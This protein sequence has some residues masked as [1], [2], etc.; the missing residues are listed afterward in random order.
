[1]PVV[2]AIVATVVDIPEEGSAF[3]EVAGDTGL[4][5]EV[6][7]LEDAAFPA[8]RWEGSA[9]FAAAVGE[10]GAWDVAAAIGRR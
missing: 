2:A 10:G 3:E 9:T 1:M 7:A 6:K 5:C 4:S 8:A